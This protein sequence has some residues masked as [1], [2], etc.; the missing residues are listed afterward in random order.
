MKILEIYVKLYKLCVKKH[1]IMNAPGVLHLH[2][3]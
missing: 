2:V 1:N 3:Y